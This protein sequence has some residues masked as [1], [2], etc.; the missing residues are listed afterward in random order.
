MNLT[1][2]TKNRTLK[3]SSNPEEKIH[4]L[5]DGKADKCEIT[6]SPTPF[7][8]DEETDKCETTTSPIPSKGGRLR[9]CITFV[10]DWKWLLPAIRFVMEKCQPVVSNLL[11]WWG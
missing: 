7:L 6:T 9:R 3:I 4:V 8:I 1:H 10:K 11:S 5:I 2:T